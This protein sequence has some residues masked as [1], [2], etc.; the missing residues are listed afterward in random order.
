VSNFFLIY[1]DNAKFVSGEMS[2]EAGSRRK[3]LH[4][5]I[6]IVAS[7]VL[8][9]AAWFLFD[10][11]RTELGCVSYWLLIFFILAMLLKTVISDLYSAW[12]YHGLARGTFLEGEIVISNVFWSRNKGSSGGFQL[13]VRYVF[14]TPEGKRLERSA[15][16]Q[17]PDLWQQARKRFKGIRP[18]SKTPSDIQQLHEIAPPPSTKLKIRY[19]DDYFFR[20][21]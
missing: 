7:L 5:F 3:L 16:V 18:F 21:M 19:V 9:F 10:A 14:Q 13:Q 4:S 15:Q 12:I 8:G 6:W 11:N 2:F 20:V 17:R 1:R